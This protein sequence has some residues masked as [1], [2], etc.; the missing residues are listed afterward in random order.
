MYSRMQRAFRRD[1]LEMRTLLRLNVPDAQTDPEVLTARQT[2]V[3]A[4]AIIDEACWNLP[5]PI[6]PSTS[7]HSRH[8][9]SH[10]YCWQLDAMLYLSI[11][12]VLI[13][14]CIVVLFKRKWSGGPLEQHILDLHFAFHIPPFLCYINRFFFLFS[15]AISFHLFYPS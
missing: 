5:Q 10:I 4:S 12:G 1:R 2:H 11:I 14:N 6:T 15:D 9:L 7:T 3:G 8:D 13:C